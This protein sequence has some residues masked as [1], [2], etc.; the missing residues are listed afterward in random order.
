MKKLLFTATLLALTS[1]GC[2]TATWRAMKCTRAY[3]SYTGETC[4]RHYV[5]KTREE[6]NSN[7]Q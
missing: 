6:K 1:A 2:S 5:D 4:H 3:Q 7:R